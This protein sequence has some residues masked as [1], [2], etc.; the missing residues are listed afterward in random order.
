[1]QER[2]RRRGACILL[3]KRAISHS[4]IR[5]QRTALRMLAA[6]ASLQTAVARMRG[7]K[8]KKGTKEALLRLAAHAWLQGALAGMRAKKEEKGKKKTLRMLATYAMLEGAV[9]G[10]R[11]KEALVRKKET[12]VRLAEYASVK[13]MRHALYERLIRRCLVCCVRATIKAWRAVAW[14]SNWKHRAYTLLCRAREKKN[15]R[16]G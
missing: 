8:E 14:E 1:M 16:N 11:E 3:R 5:Q 7:K 9:G 13:S 4:S 2:K 6:H 15:I 12:I 10:L